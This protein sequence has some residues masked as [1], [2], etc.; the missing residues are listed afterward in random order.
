ML[1]T[2]ASDVGIGAVLLQEHEGELFPVSYASRKLLPRERNYSVIERECLGLVWAVQKFYV[3]L[4]G[5]EF[6]LQTD[7]EPL[8]YLN[9]AK[10][11]NSRIMRWALVLQE[12]RFTLQSIKG[13]HNVG[14]DYMSRM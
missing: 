3:Y 8:V 4:Y 9:K 1:R 14:A 11:L 6:I 13:K 5:K 12:Y 7:H 10:L 2:D